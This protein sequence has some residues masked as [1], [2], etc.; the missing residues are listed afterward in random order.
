MSERYAPDNQWYVQ[1]M[2]NVLEVAGDVIDENIA[3]MLMR[4]IAEQ[5][6]DVHYTAIELC[7]N[8]I[9]KPKMPELLL[10]VI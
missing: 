5:E 7:M 4:L 1:T 8:I 2:F 9:D 6:A 3:H 10:K